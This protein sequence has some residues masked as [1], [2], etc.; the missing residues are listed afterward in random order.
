M[1]RLARIIGFPHHVTARGNRRE[2]IFFEDGDQD[3]YCDMLSEQMRKAKV[4][5][6]AYCLIL[7]EQALK[8]QVQIWAYCLMPNHVH[9]IAV[10]SDVGLARAIGETHRRYTN[11]INSRGRWTGH[12]FQR[13]YGS[14]VMDDAHLIAGV[15]YVSLNP[16]RARLLGAPMSGHGRACG[17]NSQVAT[18]GLSS[19]DPCSTAFQISARCWRQVKRTRLHSPPFGC[20]SGQGAV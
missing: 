5:V 4:E 18:T 16:V 6:W 15:R 7:A 17:P 13:C 19:S 11:F 14:V 9:I 20:P 1:A 10:P 8:A 2:P 12:P 3:L